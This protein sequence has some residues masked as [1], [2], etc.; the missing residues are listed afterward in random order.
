MP[1]LQ[2]IEGVGGAVVFS[3]GLNIQVLSNV[4]KQVG[5]DYVSC[6]LQNIRIVTCPLTRTSLAL[7]WPLLTSLEKR[8]TD[9]LVKI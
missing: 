1:L 8:H 6:D 5:V 3:T 9:S 2:E 7:C 4:M